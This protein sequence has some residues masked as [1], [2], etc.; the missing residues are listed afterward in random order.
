MD[1]SIDF[2][3]KVEQIFKNIKKVYHK[4]EHLKY[5]N[6][7]IMTQYLENL[8]PGDIINISGPFGKFSYIGDGKWEI[9]LKVLLGK[10]KIKMNKNDYRIIQSDL[11]YMIAGGSGKFLF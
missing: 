1:D 10:F 8:K 9:Y 3:I 7:G 11:I 6:G 2:I 4:N 5:P